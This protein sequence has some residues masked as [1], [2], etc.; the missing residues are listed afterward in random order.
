MNG[1]STGN[2]APFQ[3]LLKG[4]FEIRFTAGEGA[5]SEIAVLDTTKRRV[6][7]QQFQPVIRAAVPNAAGRHVIGPV[8]LH[9]AKPGLGGGIDAVEERAVG[10]QETEIGGEFRHGSP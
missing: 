5:Q 4:L 8:Q 1:G 9:R 10:P 3:G 6:D 2:F 7:A